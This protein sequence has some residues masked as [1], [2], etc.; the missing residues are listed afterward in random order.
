MGN[1]KKTDTHKTP[2]VENLAARF[3][4]HLQD[5]EKILFSLIIP[6]YNCDE[7]LAQTLESV[8]SQGYESLEVIVVDAGSTDR[9][10]E[11]INNYS[12][13]ITRIYTVASYNVADMMN[14]GLSLATGRYCSFI[15]PGTYYLSKWT[16][17]AFAEKVIRSDFPDMLYCGSV[18]REIKREPKTIFFPIETQ[19]LEKGQHPATLPATWFRCDLFDKLGKFNSEYSLRVEFD[20][21][22]RIAQ[23]EGLRTPML[24]RVF[25]DFDFGR[26]SYGEILRFA[27]ETWKILKEHFGWGCA[28]NWFWKR[29][30][31]SS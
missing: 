24:D 21:F 1:H 29:I 12:Q 31:R 19:L 17:A 14:R 16:F 2:L 10:L 30:R 8:K 9:T 3:L 15:F 26:F 5:E 18:Q 25:V 13:L 28:L 4:P 6:V 23:T 27:K 20:F 22:C 11:I 7:V